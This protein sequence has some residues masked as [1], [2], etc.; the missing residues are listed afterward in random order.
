MTAEEAYSSTVTY[1][2]QPRRD[3]GAGKCQ[4]LET[5]Y[6]TWSWQFD[7]TSSNVY[8]DAEFREMILTIVAMYPTEPLPLC[9]SAMKFVAKAEHG[10]TVQ[11]RAQRRG[12]EPDGIRNTGFAQVAGLHVFRDTY[13]TIMFG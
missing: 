9:Y 2:K 13:G 5:L 7:G 8:P 12:R 3:L 1:K 10:S 4:S 6:T 11:S